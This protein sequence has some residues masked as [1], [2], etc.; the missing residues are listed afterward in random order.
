ME[1][2][3][4][5]EMLISRNPNSGKQPIQRDS[6]ISAVVTWEDFPHS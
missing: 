6:E 3:T 1:N 5:G 2:P 4:Q